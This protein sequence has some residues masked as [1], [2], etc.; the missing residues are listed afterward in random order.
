MASL[1]VTYNDDTEVDVVATPRAQVETER[2]LRQQ[3]GFADSTMIEASFRLAYESLR[4][5]RMLPQV[6]GGD[7]GYEE[8]LDLIA[9]V[10]EIE[11]QADA[12]DPTRPTLAVVS[13]TPS[14]D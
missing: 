11:E 7:A 12:A 2:F 13:P 14:S 9:N 8:W 5:R 10:A 1:K 6:N 3:G 4:S